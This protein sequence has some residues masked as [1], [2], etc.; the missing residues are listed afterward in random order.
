MI[1]PPD[2]SSSEWIASQETDQGAS[3]DDGG[4]SNECN[5]NN[6]ED[7][8]AT[9]NLEYTQLSELQG[10]LFSRILADVF[11]EMDKVE[12]TI[13]KKHSLCKHFAVAFNDTMLVPDKGD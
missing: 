13:S 9:E 11:H 6:E 3:D 5:S 7:N 1:L 8:T 12:R 2:T 10:D 4:D